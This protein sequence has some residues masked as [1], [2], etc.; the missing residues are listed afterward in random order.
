[1]L[2]RQNAY[3]Y[4]LIYLSISSSTAA[5]R[6]CFF[7]VRLFQWIIFE[8]E[9][10]SSESR[11]KNHYMF[12]ACYILREVRYIYVFSI[13]QVLTA[14]KQGAVSFVEH[15]VMNLASACFLRIHSKI[16]N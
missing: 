6:T 10:Q 5:F 16:N 13:M 2:L 3:F 12:L 8:R 11:A 9:L 7:Q 14:N 4:E 15:E 1:M